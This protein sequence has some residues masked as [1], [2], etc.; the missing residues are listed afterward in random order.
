MNAQV[1]KFDTL[2][3]LLNTQP[4][5]ESVMIFV[6]DPIQVRETYS[7]RPRALFS[8]AAAVGSTTLSVMA[9]ISS[10]KPCGTY[11]AWLTSCDGFVFRLYYSANCQ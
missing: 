5:P 7:R 10:R 1:K 9:K 11:L 4:F 2:R 3:R 8:L 6:N